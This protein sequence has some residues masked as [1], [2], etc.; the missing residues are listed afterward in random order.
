[1][2]PVA[3]DISDA[4]QVT[5]RDIPL[6][7]VDSVVI[8]VAGDS[9]DGS[10]LTGTSFADASAVFG[11]DIATVQ[12]FPAEIR[13]P[14]GTPF[15]VSAF[16]LQFSS[17]D[18]RTAGDRLNALVAFNAA[19]LKAHVADLEDHGI[20][21]VDKAGFS[22]LD[23]KKAGYASN[24]LEDGALSKYRLIPIDITIQAI[25]A[26]A[27]AGVKGKDAEKCKNMYA[28]G[29]MYWLYD[30]PVEP[31]VEGIRKK[32]AAKPA[33]AEGNVAA[34]NAGYN[35]AHTVELF[36][37]HY[38]VRKA[39]FKP[40]VYRSITGNEA[41]ALGVAAA[42]KKSGRKAFFGSYPITPASSI[43]EQLT[44]YKHFGILTFQ[45]EDEISAICSSIGASWAGELAF[46]CS[47]GPGIALKSEAMNLAVMAELPLV[48]LDIQRGGPSTGLPTKTEQ[49]DLLQVL[50]GRNGD[51]PIPVIAASSP[52][53]C[54]YKLYESARIAVKYM[55]PVVFL[56]DGYIGNGSEPWMV[57]DA[58]ELKEFDT[59]ALG[60]PASY[61]PYLRDPQTGSRPWAKPGTPGFE[62]R[63][64]G[65]E[66]QS[67]TGKIMYEAENHYKMT[68]ERADKVAKIAQEIPP[69]E[70]MGAKQGKLLVVSWGGT[71][72]AVATAVEE[73]LK[74]DPSIGHI[75]LSYLNPL[76]P[77]LGSILKKYKEIIVPEINMGQLRL[78]LSG[79][80]GLP[81]KGFNQVKGKPL[82]V[83]E[84]VTAFNELLK[85]A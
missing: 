23:L 5:G 49:S 82:R 7:E 38:R 4:M 80:Y 60:D 50:F 73:A 71:Y 3:D 34:L 48:V 11:N 25:Q 68:L 31:T 22:P 57:P 41:A 6:V 36:D 70:V 44:Q 56:S 9:G 83:S 74:L 24:P 45:A 79:T 19:A 64:T 33:I 54:F 13:A 29:I 28:L 20:L 72:G 65:L 55:T 15:G 35:Y 27:A 17:H 10:Q 40:G 1:M 77:D 8:R 32:F 63:L 18:I 58:R 62:H 69:T 67:V 30:R 47:S 16:Q 37:A 59:K 53:D 81:V 85:E 12:D 42:A 66:H 61:K 75:H 51:S 46:T 43:L 78:Y 39:P 76:P 2:G 21:V 26:V 84:L 14:A 52:G